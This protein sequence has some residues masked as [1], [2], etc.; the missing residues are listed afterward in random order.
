MV[1][2]EG[3]A[4]CGRAIEPRYFVIGSSRA[5]RPRSLSTISAVAVKVFVSDA[6]AYRVAAVVGMRRVLSA[7]PNASLQTTRPSRAI[8]TAIEGA[9]PAAMTDS[10]FAR[11]SA[12]ART[13]TGACPVSRPDASAMN[14]R[15]SS[16]FIGRSL[17]QGARTTS[18]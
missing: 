5:S 15:P 2:S 3:A 18:P 12:G 13:A 8:A 11:T 7:T 14:R 17:V 1:T 16:G 9:R 4:T 10:I 6:T